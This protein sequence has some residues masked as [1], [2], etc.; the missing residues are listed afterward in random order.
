[1]AKA[2]KISSGSMAKVTKGVV[3]GVVKNTACMKPGMG[4]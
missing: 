1:M 4:K 3:K 2:K